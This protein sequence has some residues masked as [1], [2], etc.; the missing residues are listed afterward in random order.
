MDSLS[1]NNIIKKMYDGMGDV[2]ED[3]LT[4]FK[5]YSEEN[6][7]NTKD[8]ITNL[9]KISGSLGYIGQV[10]ASLAKAYEHEKR[11][12]IIEE[13]L[14]KISPEQKAQIWGT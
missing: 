12:L 6:E 7:E 4:R 14:K 8:T 5:K 13:K 11:L 10:H 9:S 1:E 2:F 3:Y